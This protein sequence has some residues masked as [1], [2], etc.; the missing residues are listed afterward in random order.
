[1]A[2]RPDLAQI[3]R[4]HADYVIGRISVALPGEVVHYDDA[5]QSASVQ[6][7]PRARRR[8]YESDELVPFDLPQIVDVPVVWPSWAGGAAGV[9]GRLVPGDAVILLVCDRSID[10][11]KQAVGRVY[12]PGDVRRCNLTDAV[13]LPGGSPPAAGLGPESRPL[14]GDPPETV[15]VRGNVK[16]GSSSAA[17]AVVTEARLLAA[18]GEL[19]ATFNG[20]THG[21]PVSGITTSPAPLQTV[22][23]AGS[24]SSDDVRAT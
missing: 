18:L 16:L 6:P 24:L 9:V 13:C 21:D 23:A 5:R 17:D 15:V 4:E 3:L 19:V 2:E 7:L 11:W 20:H 12:T 22:P 1:M 10:E 8:E 14:P